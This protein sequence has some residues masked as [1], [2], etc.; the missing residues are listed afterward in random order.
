V[1]LAT[2]ISYC[3]DFMGIEPYW[4]LFC[5][6]FDILPQ[7]DRKVIGILWIKAADKSPFFHIDLPSNI[8]NWAKKWFYVYDCLAL[9]FSHKL[10]PPLLLA[11]KEEVPEFEQEELDKLESDL[12]DYH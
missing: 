12:Q 8:P 2:F 9:A 3:E 1:L 10:P 11:E 4:A 6:C 7:F 5:S